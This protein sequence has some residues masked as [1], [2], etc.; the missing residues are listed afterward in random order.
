MADRWHGYTCQRRGVVAA[1]AAVALTD[2]TS[3]VF[4]GLGVEPNRETFREQAIEGA[5][6]GDDAASGGENES[7]VLGENKVKSLALHA[8]ITG[9]AV[10]I[11]NDSE[12]ESG[13]VFDL[14]V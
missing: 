14:F 11:E 2:D 6:I 10:E 1:G 9:V 13:V 4:F 5:G 8:A 7:R 3:H 12:S